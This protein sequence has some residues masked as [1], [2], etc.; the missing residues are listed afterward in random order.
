M[1]MWNHSEWNKN[2][3]SILKMKRT[4]KKW[5]ETS[6][7]NKK[8][9]TN[10]INWLFFIEWIKMIVVCDAHWKFHC[11]YHETEMFSKRMKRNKEEWI[12]IPLIYNTI[13]I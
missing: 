12:D 4:K 8:R 11:V 13:L 6:F 7:E 10:D 2:E 9:K 1:W 3:I 5:N